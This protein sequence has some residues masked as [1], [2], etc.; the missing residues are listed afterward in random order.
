M[1][2]SRLAQARTLAYRRQDQEEVK[3]L[4][5]RIAELDLTIEVER[6]DRKDD[7]SVE[8]LLAKVNERN[9]KANAET[10]KNIA[11][12]EEKKRRERK[13]AMANGS[14]T[15]RLLGSRYVLF[16]S[17][18]P[19]LRSL[20]LSLKPILTQPL[21]LPLQLS[22]TYSIDLGHRESQHRNLGTSHGASHLCCLHLLQ[23]SLLQ[24]LLSLLPVS[25][26]ASKRV[27]WIQSRLISAISSVLSTSASS[28]CY[29]ARI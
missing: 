23:L 11:A 19:S 28:E 14:A 5:I 29:H 18:F 26:I 10:L 15:P 9:R 6:K 3:Q 24:H 8:D 16:L 27:S 17:A 1:E 22:W 12:R 25:R 20:S 2:R 7:G 21:L 4:D 13:L